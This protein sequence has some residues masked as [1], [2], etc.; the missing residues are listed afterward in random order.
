MPTRTCPTPTTRIS[1]I[2]R[3]EDAHRPQDSA[4]TMTPSTAAT[5]AF[6][7]VTRRQLLLAALATS[8]LPSRA[9]T[10][11][12]TA[13]DTALQA[14]L[15][16]PHRSAANRARDV[17][18]HPLQTLQFFGL[19]PEMTVVELTPGGGW[20]SEILAPYLRPQ[21]RFY[22]AHF[23]ADSPSAG[24]RRARANFEARMA[25]AP[26]LY[27]RMQLGTLPQG[28]RFGADLAP[29]G[30]ADLV[31]TF[32]NVH[33]WLQDGSLDGTLQACLALLKPGG[34]LGVV[35]HRAAPGTPVATMT[36]TGYVSEALMEERATAAGFKAAGRSD[37]NAN[38]RDTREHPNGVWSL[39]PT[40]AG[41]DLD[42]ERFVAIGESDRFTHRYQRPAG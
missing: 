1:T 29:P 23:A 24:A 20:Y 39:P 17:W 25:K 33:N 42:R 27:D 8:A 14:V 4:P 11:P 30:G 21:G 9:Q 5:T 18:R 22:A 28:G 12:A 41:K 13:S 6:T 32:R 10:L 35:D 36:K 15:D 40:L 37:V 16:A 7:T 31:L 3:I 34:V 26:E 2:T 38:P 19:R